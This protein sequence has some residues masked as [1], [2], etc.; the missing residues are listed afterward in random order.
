MKRRAS[1]ENKKSFLSTH[2]SSLSKELLQKYKSN[3]EKYIQ[4]R[5]KNYHEIEEELIILSR[6]FPDYLKLTTGQELYDLPYP[7]GYCQKQKGDK[8]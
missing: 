8:K 2:I 6:Q 4:Y 3:K 1:T 5:Y 7:G